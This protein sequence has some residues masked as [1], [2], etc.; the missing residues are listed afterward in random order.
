MPTPEERVK[1]LVV[2]RTKVPAGP[3]F[4]EVKGPNVAPFF[5]GPYANKGIA[6]DEAASLR[7]FVAAVLADAR[8]PPA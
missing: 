4:V 1:E 7:K 5:L 2:A 6:H 3:W 8:P